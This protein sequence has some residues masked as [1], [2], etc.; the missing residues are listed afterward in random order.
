MRITRL[1]LSGFRGIDRLVIDFP[2]TYT[3]VFFG[4][5]GVGKTSVLDAIAIMFQPWVEM[6]QANFLASGEQPPLEPARWEGILAKEMRQGAVET[7]AELTVSHEGHQYVWRLEANRGLLFMAERTELQ[8]LRQFVGALS[9]PL[10]SALA[11]GTLGGALPLIVLYATNRAILDVPMRI[12][13]PHD[14][15]SPVAALEGSLER[16]SNDFRLFFE[17]FQERENVENER[18]VDDPDHRD[19]QLEGVRRAVEAVMGEC[20]RELRVRRVPLRMTLLKDD[21]EIRVEHLSDGE[22]CLLAMTGDLA[23]RLA[24]ANPTLENPLEGSAVALIDE[25]ELHLHP[26]WQR[27]VLGRLHEVFP[28][29]QFIVSTHSPQVLGEVPN[30]AAF[31]MRQGPDG[32]THEPAGGTFGRDSNQILVAEMDVTERD[33]DVQA[34][35]DRAY[36]L[37]EAQQL[38]R[39]R[40][41]VSE[42]QQRLSGSDAALSKL[43]ALIR[44]H[45]ILGR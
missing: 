24:I 41:V 6:L 43:E 39:A 27:R 19:R 7:V 34:A 25:I 16:G 20:Y 4:A 11:A 13:T 38:D 10:A 26:S 21:T 35:I 30:G 40:E 3:T 44:R 45:E 1:R 33:E 17:W 8:G 2:E 28:N 29:T 22:K 32:A 5:N 42:L 9:Q 23:R 31:L 18:R 15:S 37:L 36:E 12:R 14:F